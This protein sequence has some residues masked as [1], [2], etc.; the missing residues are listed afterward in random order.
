MVSMRASYSRLVVPLSVLS[1]GVLLLAG[2]TTEG[3]NP[4]ET[5]KPSSSPSATAE[6]SPTAT[7]G[8]SVGIPVTIGCDQLLSAQVIYDYNSN[9]GLIDD[10][11][12]AAGSWAAKAVADKGIACRWTNQT[13]GENIDVSVVNLPDE[14]LTALK[15][16]FVMSSNSV[17]TYGVEG[18]F[19]VK[20]AY[21][22]AHAFADPYMITIVSDYFMEPGDAAPLMAA[23]IAALG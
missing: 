9:F 20:G 23:A 13:S 19:A 1:L 11:T 22:E 5:N 14:Q 7:A 3:E 4:T 18:Y 8:E 21:G 12:P 15:N 2:C 10:Y 17:P 16:D 6:P